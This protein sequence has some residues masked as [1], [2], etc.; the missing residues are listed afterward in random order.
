MELYLRGAS[1]THALRHMLRRESG[2]TCCVNSK[3]HLVSLKLG[4]FLSRAV[5]PT[6]SYDLFFLFDCYKLVIKGKRSQKIAD[7]P[8]FTLSIDPEHSPSW[9]QIHSD[10]TAQNPQRGLINFEW[11]W[12]PR[13]PNPPRKPPYPRHH[14]EN[15]MRAKGPP[16]I[17]PHVVQREQ[18]RQRQTFRDA[19]C[20]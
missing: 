6:P 11:V 12:R 20:L 3:P 18:G 14:V 10:E 7:P 2:P 16:R 13:L 4:S 5:S 19:A 9:V 17:A 15:H 8:L 1:I